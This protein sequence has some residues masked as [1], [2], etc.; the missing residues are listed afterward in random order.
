[1]TT[2]TLPAAE[3]ALL[4]EGT[5]I[6]AHPLALTADRRLDERRQRALTRYYVDAGAGGLA[7]AVHTTQFAIREPSI[8]LLRPVLALAAET[9]DAHVGD[10]PFLRIAGACGPVEQAVAEAELAADLGY[11]AVL[12]SPGG[13]DR[14]DE[15]ALIDRAAAVGQV[16]PVIGFYLQ[17][18]V[19]GRRLSVDFWRRLADLPQV[20]AIKAAPF[21]RYRTLDVARGLAASDRGGEV[22]LYTGNDDSI[23]LDLLG[24]AGG[25]VVGGLLGQ[26]AVWTAGAVHTWELARRARQGDGAA[27]RLAVERAPQLTDANGAVFDVHNAF[28]GCIAGVHEVLRGQGLLAGTW[29][30]DPA[31]DL[32][33][34][35]AAEI[36][37]VRTAYPWLL[38]DD[39]V[40]EHRDRWLR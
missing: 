36:D 2:T 26:W 40:A 20:V 23:L 34:G 19:G 13:L 1:M 12:L 3:A 31:E 16:L 33:P 38:D 37:R 11:H 28:H 4:A 14:L 30:L 6:P 5:V 32:S 29:C 24:G 7:V 25:R 27:L 10:R 15:A 35:Q 17:E 8:G 39:F 18:A 22:A 9:M 21:D